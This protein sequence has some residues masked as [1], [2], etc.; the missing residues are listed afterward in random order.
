MNHFVKRQANGN[1]VN[2]ALS[3]ASE[4]CRNNLWWPEL[5]GMKGWRWRKIFNIFLEE[6]GKQEGNILR[7]GDESKDLIF[8]WIQERNPHWNHL[9]GNEP[10]NNHWNALPKGWHGVHSFRREA[11]EFCSLAQSHF[12]L[13]VCKGKQPEQMS[14]FW[15]GYS[16]IRF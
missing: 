5:D 2:V 7:Q 3:S 16:Q 15:Q 8:L 11:G 1:I 14:L 10:V 9:S 4:K 13:G 12:S 6:G